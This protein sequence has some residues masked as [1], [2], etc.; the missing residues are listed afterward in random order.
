MIDESGISNGIDVVVSEKYIVTL[1]EKIVN[2][3]D[4]NTC[5]VP[6]PSPSGTFRLKN[7]FFVHEVSRVFY[8]WEMIE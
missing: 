2:S 3:S 6:E 4:F 5:S 1:S 8:T 7:T